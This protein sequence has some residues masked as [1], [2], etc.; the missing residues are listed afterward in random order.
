M[1]NGIWGFAV[2][3]SMGIEGLLEVKKGLEPSI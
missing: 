2:E 3:S 1:H